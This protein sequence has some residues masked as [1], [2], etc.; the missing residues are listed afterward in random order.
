MS[1]ALLHVAV[2]GHKQGSGKTDTFPWKY[3]AEVMLAWMMRCVDGAVERAVEEGPLT[4]DTLRIEFVFPDL[5]P[6][7]A[8]IRFY[9][10]AIAELSSVVA[11]APE[12]NG[13]N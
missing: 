2:G 8:F 11:I 4:I 6:R 5:I 9:Q 3:S 13:R 1:K 12:D 10:K 7:S